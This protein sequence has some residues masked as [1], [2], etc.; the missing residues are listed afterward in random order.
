MILQ[1][2]RQTQ[3][4]GGLPSD[5]Y[6]AI[7]YHAQVLHPLFGHELL[8]TAADQNHLFGILHQ[9]SVVTG[10]FESPKAEP[11][12]YEWPG[13]NQFWG[14]GKYLSS[15]AEFKVHKRGAVLLYEKSDF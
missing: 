4:V 11:L 14:Q 2:T 3:I 7:F 9:Q 5:H 1:A 10:H 15:G 6:A 12:R 13:F 8:S